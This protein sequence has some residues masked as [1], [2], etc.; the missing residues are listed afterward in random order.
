MAS[1]LRAVEAQLRPKVAARRDRV[2]GSSWKPVTADMNEAH[3]IST[4]GSWT[5]SQDEG[6]HPQAG[7]P[8][9][10]CLG[11]EHVESE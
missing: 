4:K 10:F 11:K 5:S 6:G 2:W 9:G 1:P 3:L 8:G 7:E